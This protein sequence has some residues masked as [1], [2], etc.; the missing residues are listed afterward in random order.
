VQQALVALRARDGQDLVMVTQGDGWV[1]ANEPAA[2]TQ[3]SFTPAGHAAHPAL[4]RRQVQYDANSR[5]SV[6]LSSLCEG[7]RPACDQLHAEFTALNDRFLQ[8][9][10]ARSRQP[11]RS[12]P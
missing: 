6:A 12:Q 10:R 5:A 2:A 4:V 3:W 11:Q 7:P 1:I 9:L 8:A